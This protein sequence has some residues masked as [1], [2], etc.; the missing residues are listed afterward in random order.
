MLGQTH[1]LP[2]SLYLCWH[3]IFPSYLPRGQWDTLMRMKSNLRSLG[4]VKPIVNNFVDALRALGYCCPNSDSL[5]VPLTDS[6]FA[7]VG[8]KQA[9]HISPGS[10]SWRISS[11]TSG[12]AGKSRATG[13]V[14]AQLTACTARGE[15]GKQQ[16]STVQTCTWS[17]TLHAIKRGE[18]I[19]DDR[20]SHLCDWPG[21]HRIKAL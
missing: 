3:H 12:A 4:V 16:L 13:V 11:R 10:S 19:L 14:N 5:Y 2:A 20:R 18:E 1:P 6:I 17:K 21:F 9:S 7:N 8:H 15:D